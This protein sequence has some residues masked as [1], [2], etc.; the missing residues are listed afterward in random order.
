LP[1][2]D[3]RRIAQWLRDRE[4]QRQDEYL[5]TAYREV[6][7]DTERERD[8]PEWSEGIIGDLATGRPDAP[9]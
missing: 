8:A 5:G 7:L 9:R 2:E 6:A 3:I 1:P 4:K